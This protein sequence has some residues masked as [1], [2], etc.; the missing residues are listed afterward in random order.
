MRTARRDTALRELQERRAFELRLTPDRALE[1]FDDAVEFLRDRGMLT[2]SADSA[3]PSLFEACH[4]DPYAPDK[5]GFGQWPRTK[6]SWS[7]M[8]AAQ[9]GVY[10]PKIHHR[11]KTLYVSDETARLLDPIIRAELDRMNGEPEWALVLEHLDAAGASSA[12]D[13]QTELGLKPPELKKLLYPLELCGV[14]VNRAIEPTEDGR[15]DGH[16]YVRWDQAFPEAAGGGAR[17]D[18][19]VVA[20]VRAAVV[21]PEREITKWFAWRWR[22]DADLLDRLV[23]EGRLMRPELGWIAIPMSS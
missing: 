4:E 22:F 6:W 14:V 20:A 15:V 17:L 1:T 9:P 13:L 10:A 18:D 7:F 19:F 23:A 8:L 21:A 3:L 12:E 11:R 2:R 5:Q 16:E